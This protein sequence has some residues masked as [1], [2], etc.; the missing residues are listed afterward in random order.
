MAEEQDFNLPGIGTQQDTGM[1]PPMSGVLPGI[2]AQQTARRILSKPG[3]A[4]T[5]LMDPEEAQ[6]PTIKPMT[7]P[8]GSP[9]STEKDRGSLISSM[10][11]KV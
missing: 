2:N 9:S 11:M 1:T 6:A 7:L 4:I 10:F 3:A 5:E 8:A